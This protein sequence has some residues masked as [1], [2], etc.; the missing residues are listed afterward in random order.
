MGWQGRDDH[1]L[2]RDSK[3]GVLPT[4]DNVV[5]ILDRDD[6]W[7]GVIAYNEFSGQVMKLK[8]APIEQGE[9]GEWTDMDDARLELWL[10]VNYGLRRMPESTL[11]RGVAL[12]ADKNRYHEVRDFL[13]GLVWD[14]VPRLAEWLH[15]YMG[16]EQSEYAALAGTKFLVGAVARILRAPAPTKMELVLT[17]SGPQGAGKSTALKVLFWPWF[18]DSAFEIGSTDGYQIIRGSW[19]VE[20][21]EL[22]GFNRAENSKSKGFFSREIDRYRSP[23][24]RKPINV[25]RQCVFMGSVNHTT[26]LKDDSGNRRHLPVTVGAIYI[27]ELRAD[28]DQLWAEAVDAYRRGTSWWVAASESAIFE[29]EQEQH[30][31]GDAY[32]DRI[33]AW[34]NESDPDTHQRISEVTTRRILADCLKLEISKW[35]MA[36]QIR[37]GRIMQRM[38]WS[39]RRA[40][41]GSRE[42]VY[43]RPEGK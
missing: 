24:G 11:Q 43:V 34:M 17:L 18:T 26:W 7:D 5:L 40:G 1:L 28:R 3:G 33:R 27:E 10:A 38:G 23:Y 19:G 14:G 39:R 36:E 2:A 22:D 29:G 16:A 8:I 4:L 12:A 31:T 25:L 37:V 30:Y 32:E 35:T 42:W 9:T 41:S 21:A 13:N 20:M 6:R 15:A